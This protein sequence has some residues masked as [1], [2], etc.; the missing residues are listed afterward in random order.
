MSRLQYTMCDARVNYLNAC[1]DDV[2]NE[3]KRCRVAAP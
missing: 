1:D 2:E 3:T